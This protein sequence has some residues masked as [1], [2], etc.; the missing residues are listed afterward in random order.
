MKR[1]A[2]A[3]VSHRMALSIRRVTREEET[4]AVRLIIAEFREHAVTLFERARGVR[5]AGPPGSAGAR[6]AAPGARNPGDLSASPRWRTPGRSSTAAPRRVARRALRRAG[7]APPAAGGACCLSIAR[8]PRP[9]RPAA[10]RNRARGRPRPRARRGALR[11]RGVR[12]PPAISVGASPPRQA[13]PHHAVSLPFDDCTGLANSSAKA[14]E[15][16][17]VLDRFE[18]RG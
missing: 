11:A 5:R 12:A 4:A 6:R 17:D 3:A 8:A 16:C 18:S 7:E 9:R 2:P 1:A 13:G 14:S 15:S 10:S